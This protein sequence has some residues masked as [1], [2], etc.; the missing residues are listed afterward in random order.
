[1]HTAK[2]EIRRQF[3]VALTI[4]MI[5]C[6]GAQQAWAATA[7]TTT[8]A[9]TSG[10]ILVTTV[11]PGSVVT[12][13]ATVNAG[14]TKLTTGQVS[15]CDA[16][17]PHCTDVHLLGTAQLTSTGTAVWNFSPGAGSHSYKAVF[18]GT[19]RDAGSSSSASALTVAGEYATA[20]TIAEAG[21]PGNY[22]L[23]AMVAGSVYEVGLGSPTGT[24]SFLDTSS[25]NQVL[26]V[27]TLQ[28]VESALNWITRQ[29]EVPI[30]YNEY[31]WVAV[32]DFNGDGKPDLALTGAIDNNTVAI[33]LGNGDGTFT[34]ASSPTTANYPI[35]IAVGDFN[36]DGIP[37]LVVAN[38]PAW[39]LTILLGNGDGTFTAVQESPAA[40]EY[41]YAIGVGDFNGD[42]KADLA[43]VDIDSNTVTILLG[44][45]DGTFTPGP[46]SP[47]TGVAPVAI[48][49]GDFNGDGIPDLAVANEN[50]AQPGSV[51]ILLGN[52]DGTFRAAPSV[53]LSG[54]PHSMAL[55]DFNGDGKPDLALT[56][57]NANNTVA[58]LLGNGDGTFTPGPQTPAT[59]SQYGGIAVGDFNGDG[60][61]DLAVASTSGV[62]VLLGN[63]DGTFRAASPATTGLVTGSLVVAD[64]N[65]DG[66][67]D[68]AGVEYATNSYNLATVLL[69]QV[70]ETAS[71]TAS[72]ISPAG[73]GPQLVDASY[74]GDGN[75]SSSL[76]GTLVLYSQPPPTTTT[77]AITSGGQ[78]VTTVSSGSVVTLTATVTAYGMMVTTGQVDFCDAAAPHCT[79][80]HLL[81]TAQLT[82]AGTAV[83]NFVPG[84]GSH[85]YKAVFLGTSSEL[86]SSSSG[87]PLTVTGNYLT[88]TAIAESGSVGNYTLT[89]TVGSDGGT[90]APTGTVSFE[91]ASN[92]NAVL[93]TVALGTGTAG[94]NWLNSQTPATGHSP[95]SIAVGDFNGDGKADLVVTDVNDNVVTI[96]LGNGQGAFTPVPGTLAGDDTNAVAVG[97]FNGDGK[98]DLAIAVLGDTNGSVTILLGNGDGTFTAAPSPATGNTPQ[99]LVVADFNGDGK[100]DLAVANYDSDNLTILLG[101]GD[102]TFTSAPSPATG[103][104]PYS[105][106]VGDFNGDGI[107]DLAVGNSGSNTLTILLG[108]GDGT[109]RAASSP[110]TGSAPSAVVVGDFNGDGKADLAVANSASDTVTILLGNGDGTFTLRSTPATG[111]TPASMAV[112]DLNGDGKADLAIA[113]LY[114]NDVTILLGNGD[115]TFIAATRPSTGRNPICVAVGDFNGDGVPDLATANFTDNSVSVLVANRWSAQASASHVS[116]AG[117]PAEH[118]VFAAYAGDGVHDPSN[119]NTVTLLPLLLL[120][121]SK[122]GTGSGTVT[123]TDG[124]INCGNTCSHGYFSGTQVNLVASPSQYSSFTSWGGCDSMNGQDCSLNM[125]NNRTAT[126]TFTL[127]PVPLTVSTNGSGTVTSTDGFINC[128]GTCSHT[129]PPDAQVT[130]N[131]TPGQGWVFG[132]W[133]GPCLGT[134][135][136]NLTMTQAFA[137]D[138]IFSQA[139]QL[140]TVT[141]CRV[142]D[143]RRANG[144]FGG[145][146]IQGGTNRSFPLPQGGCNIPNLAA[147]YSLNVTVVPRGSLGYLTIWPTAEIQ[148]LVSTLNSPD[149][150]VKANGAIVPAGADGAV[151]VYV[152]DT[153]DVI[154]D[155]DGYFVT[156]GSQTLQF[157]PLTPCRLVDTRGTDGPLGGPRLPAQEERDFPLLTSGCIPPGLN[158]LAYSLNFTVVPNPGGQQLGYLTVWPAGETQPVVSTLNNPTAT[159]VADAAIVPSGANGAIAVYAFN[160]TDLLI[161]INGYFAAPGQG[162][163]SF[164]PAAPCRAY[165]SRANN[166]QPFSGERTVN[167]VGSPCTPPSNAQAY[168]FNATIVPSGSLGYLTL[169]PDSEGMPVVSTLNA[170][171]GFITSNMAIVPNVNGSIDSYAA[172]LTQLI[173]D[174]SGYF[175]P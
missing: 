65:G 32:G 158:P 134:G 172:G 5:L 69:S 12:L 18:L 78:I 108:N 45:G 147:A 137:V 145:P 27:A 141:P 174:I 16:A 28:Q 1:M 97:D 115:G 123:S 15:F 163:Y 14:A 169:W 21:L 55:G 25:G 60:K 112:G 83:L 13:T 166:G 129:Y 56:G 80:I 144:T 38:S 146:P 42:G 88:T 143:T 24:V 57:V 87:S 2:I 63:G 77:L 9:V 29:T 70:T 98:A 49:V 101:K 8:L 39:T 131:A 128:P 79:D 116:V 67:P 99:A 64:F 136:C 165:D 118:A 22:T 167:I 150:R 50:N 133:D 30:Q 173:L 84:I 35:A 153:T 31:L 4:W 54:S 19:T 82:S 37:D 71:A 20:T 104:G 152:T 127:G 90:A 68:L 121:V 119:S 148:P 73:S 26:G 94:P 6:W 46:Q 171:D 105:L 52:G 142:V 10:G 162:G 111:N 132:G 61:V 149:G 75:Y 125:N 93:A 81:G 140:V 154:L 23:T 155:V 44:N 109:F 170:Y 106:A 89:A 113:D 117:P 122:T 3:V 168:V 33:L 95:E 160:T 86:P 58:I 48:V 11:L 41:P 126:A 7:T 47:A 102:G 130:L 120:T 62:T 138:G 156:A 34:L 96:L 103:R 92:G 40:G 91:D 100:A 164:Y 17:A 161:D 151:S 159:V 74:P 43:V 66:R 157:Y 51:T 114:G 85:S 59:G 107:P 76:S 53:N 175:A 36:G 135:S 139:L 72:G 124:F 110:A